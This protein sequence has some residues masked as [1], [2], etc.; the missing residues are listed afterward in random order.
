MNNSTNDI[1]TRLQEVHI[2]IQDLLAGYVD[3]MLDEHSIALVEAHLSGCE[4]CRMDVSRQRLLADKLNKLSVTR[5]PI[6]LH[7][8][9]DHAIKNASNT[10]K[11]AAIKQTRPQ[12]PLQTRWLH[13]LKRPEFILAS[14]WAVAAVLL[15]SILYPRFIVIT[16]HK[17]PMV[18]EVLSEYRYFSGTNLPKTDLDST[19]ITPVSWPDSRL[20]AAW[21]T[22]IGGA[23]AV[24]FAIRSKNS[25]V[26]QFRISEKVFFHNP[27]VRH[28]IAE[29]GS[30]QINDHDLKVMA[31]P[32]K[33][34]GILMVG[35]ANKLPSPDRLTI[36]NS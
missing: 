30:Y 13:K 24:V 10:A 29:K 33:N 28:A 8:K 9:I 21:K 4:A 20:L 18:K 26:F 15:I 1:Q 34:A 27:D 32:I 17:I 16:G 35:P 23:P 5:M 11:Q 3:N 22:D 7:R 25:I 31:L 14:G 2:Q 36:N 6:Q 12:R 19:R